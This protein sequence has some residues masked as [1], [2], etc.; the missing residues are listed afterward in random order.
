MKIAIVDDH[1]I[2][3]QSLALLLKHRSG[4]EVIGDFGSPDALLRQAVDPPDCLLLDYH[5]PDQ[6]SLQALQRVK[7]RWPTL[8]VVF[9]TGTGSATVL[10]Q[11]LASEADGV[12]H[13]SDSADTILALLQRLSKGER[14]VSPQ[15][16]AQI[17]AVDFSFTAKEFAVL[18]GLLQGLTPDQIADRLAISRR[19]V[20]KH[21]ENMMRKASV[22]N[23]GQLLEL[24][25]R[26]LFEW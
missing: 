10:Q 8:R 24:G 1:D 5:L 4:H 7:R 11:L 12:L 23:L 16:Q 20:E 25:H 9:L 26:L 13:K 15:V 17:D 3:R 6:S 18:H 19:T 2:F 14:V 22:R 21:K